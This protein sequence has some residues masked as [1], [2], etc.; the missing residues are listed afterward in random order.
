MSTD[1]ATR[2]YLTGKPLDRYYSDQLKWLGFRYGAPIYR[3]SGDFTIDQALASLRAG[4]GDKAKEM[5][6][7]TKIEQETIRL[8]VTAV[9]SYALIGGEGFLGDLFGDNRGSADDCFILEGLL[10]VSVPDGSGSDFAT[11]DTYDTYERESSMRRATQADE[12]N[13]YL[14]G[15]AV[16]RCDHRTGQV[17]N[18]VIQRVPSPADQMLFIPPR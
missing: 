13:R 5:R 16:I 1:P 6:F 2:A 17:I 7:T 3:A 15:L 9:R 8:H 11:A 18:A 10:W 12:D 4:T 14:K